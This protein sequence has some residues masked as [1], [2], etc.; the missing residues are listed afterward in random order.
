MI[1]LLLII[2][3]GCLLFGKDATKEA[4]ATFAFVVFFL[5]IIAA[6]LP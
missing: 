5:L 1:I 2:I 4:M 3:A 6:L